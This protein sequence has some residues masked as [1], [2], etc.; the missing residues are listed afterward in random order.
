MGADATAFVASSM[1]AMAAAAA[2]PPPPPSPLLPPA[3][4]PSVCSPGSAGTSHDLTQPHV[5]PTD[6]QVASG[7]YKKGGTGGHYE[8]MIKQGAP[9]PQV[10]QKTFTTTADEQTTADIVVVTKREDRPDGVVLGFFRLA[11]LKKGP[12]GIPKIEV[13]SRGLSRIA[14]DG[15]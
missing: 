13:R 7:P 4:C 8:P 15:R 3:S 6:P 2:W 14:T 9:A 10:A 11:G 12:Q 5:P 1:A